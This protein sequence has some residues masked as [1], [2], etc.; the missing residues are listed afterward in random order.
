M[1]ESSRSQK[2]LHIPGVRTKTWTKL[3]HGFLYLLVASTMLCGCEK[4]TIVGEWMEIQSEGYPSAD[5]RILFTSDGRYSEEH[6]VDKPT[7]D[8]RVASIGSYTL[9]GNVLTLKVDE[10]YRDGKKMPKREI[11]IYRDVVL[12]RDTLVLKSEKYN[13]ISIFARP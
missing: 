8:V 2:I 13:V 4:P 1:Q 3:V 9:V 10:V 11:T 7:G 12:E 6:S 5:M